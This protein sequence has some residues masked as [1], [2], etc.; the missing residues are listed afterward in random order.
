[1]LKLY[2]LYKLHAVT[3]SQCNKHNNID[4]DNNNMPINQTYAR[5]FKLCIGK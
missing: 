2:N 5:H 3:L 4:K 1:M